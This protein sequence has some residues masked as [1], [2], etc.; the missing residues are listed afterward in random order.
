MSFEKDITD[1]KKILEKG[2]V[3]KPASTSTLAKRKEVRQKEMEARRN[4]GEDVCPHCGADLRTS[5]VYA[6]ETVY[7]DVDLTWDGSEWKY[8]DADFQDSETSGYHCNDCKEDVERG[9]DFDLGF[10][11]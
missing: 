3:F 8:G 5:G 1:I 9:K 4:K 10:E 7:Q 6:S 2:E 11:K